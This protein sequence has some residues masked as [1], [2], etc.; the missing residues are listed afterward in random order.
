MCMED[1]KLE[2]DKEVDFGV[3]S[4]TCEVLSAIIPKAPSACPNH[5]LSMHLL[6]NQEARTKN[7]IMTTKEK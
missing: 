2:R 3:G 7:L 5:V 1:Q 4:C 6:A